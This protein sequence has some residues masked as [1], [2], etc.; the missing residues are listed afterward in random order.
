MRTKL[1]GEHKKEDKKNPPNDITSPKKKK[2]PNWV[3]NQKQDVK[4][5]L[6]WEPK[7]EKKP[8][9]CNVKIPQRS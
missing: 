4:T 7:R 6:Q 2:H 1:H 9:K 8:K 3:Q 5:G